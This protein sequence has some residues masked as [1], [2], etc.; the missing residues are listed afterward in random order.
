MEHLEGI[1][2]G[3]RARRA[4]LLGHH[5]TN[6]GAIERYRVITSEHAEMPFGDGTRPL[7]QALRR[8]AAAAAAAAGQ[9]AKD[10]QDEEDDGSGGGGDHRS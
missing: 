5:K 7:R 2:Q 1:L 4:H 9:A 8:L 6:G 3:R 10:D